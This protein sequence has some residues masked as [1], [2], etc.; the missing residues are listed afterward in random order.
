M[1]YAWIDLILQYDRGNTNNESHKKCVNTGNSIQHAEE[2]R[3]EREA[4]DG[5][6]WKFYKGR[7]KAIETKLEI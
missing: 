2:N 7:I 1:Y 6:G 5:G 4:C 3:L